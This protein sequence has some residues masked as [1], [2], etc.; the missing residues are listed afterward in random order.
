VDPLS[1]SDECVWDQ[2]IKEIDPMYATKR[3]IQH[4]PSGESVSRR[5]NGCPQACGLGNYPTTDGQ[6]LTPAGAELVDRHHTNERFM[7]ETEPVRDFLLRNATRLTRQRADAEDLV[8]ETLLKA[9]VSF[10]S[11]R[12]GTH[13]KSWLSRIM[14]NAWIDKHRS[15]QRRPVEQLSGDVP[16]TLRGGEACHASAGGRVESAETRALQALPGDAELALRGLPDDVRQVVY[17]ACI[18]GYRNTEIAALLNLPVGTV[19]SR[20]H[21]GKAFLRDALATLIVTTPCSGQ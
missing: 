15:A 6:R 9:Y 5:P 10:G 8:Q 1:G 17:Y 20:L 21:R 4:T 19:G 14:A 7:R 13:F 11:Y 16:D 12:D 18:A 3:A 2:P